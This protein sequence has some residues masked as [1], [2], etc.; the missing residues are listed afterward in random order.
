MKDK[1]FYPV[2]YMF[3]VTAFFSSIVIGFAR[4]TQ[5]RVD[6]NKQIAF[7]RAVLQASGQLADRSTVAIHETFLQIIRGFHVDFLRA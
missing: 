5:D 3:I 6:A 1:P 7:E 2:V 4:F